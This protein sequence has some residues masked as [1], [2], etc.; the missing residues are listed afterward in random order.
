MILYRLNSN[1]GKKLQIEFLHKVDP[2]QIQIFGGKASNLARLLQ[3]GIAVPRGFAI[4]I[5]GFKQF[6]SKCRNIKAFRIIQQEQDDVEA[7]LHSAKV[8]NE[9][10]RN[11]KIP[12]AITNAIVK[13]IQQLERYQG[14]SG[15]GFAIR[16]SAT[17]EDTTQFSFAGQADTFLCVRGQSQILDA[18][19]QTWLSI[20]SPRSILYLQ[21][22]GIPIDQIQMGV[23]V[24]EMVIGEI[25]GVLFTA[26]V[27]TNNPNQMFLEA[28]WGLGESLVSGKV[29][30][31]SFLIGKSPLKIL[32]RTIGEKLLYSIP[33]PIEEPTST[34]ILE[35]P[36]AKRQIITLD[37][38]S[39]LELAQIGLKIE[40]M[41]G[42]PQ[43]IE[44]T[45]RNGTFIILQTRPITTL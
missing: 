18:I 27:T 34:R 20:Y 17:I 12:R 32:K 15:S 45:Y 9:T 2:D 1:Y 11:Y 21:S 29:N 31:D 14:T 23:L 3:A 28:T 43:D 4:S 41:M 40:D 33:Y 8:F 10:A 42:C 30:P 37:D 22:M 39:I 44:W 6:L 35:T 13:G 5:E 19:K 24:Q 26:N 25:S 38:S 16:S 36:S 7:I